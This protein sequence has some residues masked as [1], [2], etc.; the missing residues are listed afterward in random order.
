MDFIKDMGRKSPW[1]NDFYFVG[2]QNRGE[3]VVA[4][5]NLDHS[6]PLSDPHLIDCMT[7]SWI[8]GMNINTNK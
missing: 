1:C 5:G 8:R 7:L 3:L 2:L 6:Q 4:G